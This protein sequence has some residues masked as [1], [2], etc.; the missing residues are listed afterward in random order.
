MLLHRRLRL[1][2]ACFRPLQSAPMRLLLLAL[3]LACGF[4]APA[5]A[6]RYALT[7]EGLGMRF[8]PLGQIT[9][10]ADVA[11]D[12]YRVDATL[13]S[14]GLLNLFEPT[15]IRAR[16][17]GRIEQG[18]VRWSSYHLDHRYSQK[19]R[20]IEMQ[21]ERGGA[22][23]AEITPNY[24]LWGDPAATDDQRRRSRD[25]LSTVV[26]MAIDVGQSRRCSGAYPTFDGRFHYLMELAGGETGRF[27]D[28]GYNGPI[29]KCTLAYIAIAGYERTDRGR[30]RIPRGEIWFALA[31]NSRFAPPVR[32][33]T[34]LSA[35]GA[36]I[37]LSSWRRAEVSI[38]TDADNEAIGVPAQE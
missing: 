12:S 7:Y 16:A 10:D 14:G 24:R 1:W 26:A 18:V 13:R 17:A 5:A 2:T 37:R 3:M 29:L 32:I 11:D 22:I 35:G 4:A 25:P 27:R 38:D 30:R 23:D 28:G 15:N 36:T 34:P 21:A 31:D 9:L 6:D 20:V 19:R 33:A 8:V